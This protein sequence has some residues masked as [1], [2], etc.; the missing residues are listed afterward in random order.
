MKPCREG[1]ASEALALPHGRA[2]GAARD[3]GRQIGAT[4]D[5]SSFGSSAAAS[6][7]RVVRLQRRATLDVLACR[8]PLPV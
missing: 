2:A 5:H 6:S 7:A 4:T 3:G 1:A 8:R